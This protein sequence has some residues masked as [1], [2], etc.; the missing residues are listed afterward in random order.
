MS[1]FRLLKSRGLS[2][3]FWITKVKLRI[4][5]PWSAWKCV[6]LCVWKIETL[7]FDPRPIPYWLDMI[8]QSWS[9]LWNMCIPIPRLNPVGFNSHKFYFLWQHLVILNYDLTFLW[10]WSC[11]LIN[12]SLINWTSASSDRFI[13]MTLSNILLTFK[14][15]V[16]CSL[17][18]SFW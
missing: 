4:F 14:N 17:M 11:I 15:K 16:T 1:N 9:K 10:N 12:F 13:Y 7:S 8:S 6:W 18:L 2:I 5:S 3:N